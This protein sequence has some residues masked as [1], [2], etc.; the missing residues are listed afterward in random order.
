MSAEL[1]VYYKLDA[2]QA[3]AAAQAFAA[4]AGTAPV[5]LL[6]RADGDSAAGALTWMEIYPAEAVAL[7]PV[8]AAALRPF[9][10]GAR[11]IERF[12]PRA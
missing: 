5:R 7:E 10:A 6:Q 8:V 2:A 11:H 12:V 9:I 3:E 4:A 1:Y